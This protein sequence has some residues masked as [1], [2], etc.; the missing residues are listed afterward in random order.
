MSGIWTKTLNEITQAIAS[1]PK[2]ASWA[3]L[4]KDDAVGSRRC[5]LLACLI[6]SC[7]AWSGRIPVSTHVKL[8]AAAPQ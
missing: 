7:H 1:E 5:V 3:D 2:Q 8:G 4:L 6:N